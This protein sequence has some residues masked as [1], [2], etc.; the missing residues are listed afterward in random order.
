MHMWR[1]MHD[2]SM[3]HYGKSSNEI[4]CT[5]LSVYCTD[6]ARGLQESGIQDVA[7]LFGAVPVTGSNLYKLMAAH[8][9][10][11]LLPGGVREALKPKVWYN[12]NAPLHAADFKH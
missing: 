8:E 2:K 7:R 11:L 4:F 6:V 9:A 12:K 10:V 5:F 3:W 1:G